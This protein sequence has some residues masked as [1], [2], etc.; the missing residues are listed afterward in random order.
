MFWLSCAYSLLMRR[1]EK[2]AELVRRAEEVLLSDAVAGEPIYSFRQGTHFERNAADLRSNPDSP[3]SS[4]V[5]LG[6]VT[7]D[8]CARTAVALRAK[9]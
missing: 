2:A 1:R 7:A 3:Y 5:E 4:F 8:R 6:P 9:D